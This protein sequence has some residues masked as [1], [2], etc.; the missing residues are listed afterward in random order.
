[1]AARLG[2]VLRGSDTAGRVGGDEF[3]VVCGDL[4]AIDEAFAVAGRLRDAMGQAVQGRRPRRL[5][6]A[7]ASA[8]AV[9]V[10]HGRR[11]EYVL[12]DADL[13]MYRAKTDGARAAS[14]CS[15]SRC[16]HAHAT[17]ANRDQ[18]REAID[19]AT[20]P[21]SNNRSATSRTTSCTAP[22]RCSAGGLRGRGLL[23]PVDFL[24][25]AEDSSSSCD[26][27]LGPAHGLLRRCSGASSSAP[28]SHRRSTSRATAVEGS[29]T[30]SVAQVLAETGRHA[31]RDPT[32]GHRDGA[33]RRRTMISE[34]RRGWRRS[35]YDRWTTSGPATRHST[36]LSRS[37]PFPQDRSQLRGR[38]W[39]AAGGRA[40]IE[41]LVRLGNSLTLDVMLRHRDP[42]AARPARE[43][44][45]RYAQG[46]F[47]GIPA[48]PSC[49]STT[50]RGG[51]TARWWRSR[52]SPSRASGRATADPRTRPP[53]THQERGPRAR[54]PGYRPGCL[55]RESSSRSSSRATAT[56]AAGCARPA[57]RSRARRPP[58]RR[59][60]A[61]PRPPA[62]L[63]SRCRPD[64]PALGTPRRQR[65]R[66]RRPSRR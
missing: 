29:F 54:P 55:A 32:R 44:R 51:S 2:S 66:S 63:L 30:Q 19:R 53:G 58:Q 3:V 40:I 50:S 6:T 26:R 43:P 38:A 9:G 64:A 37:R 27:T 42:R 8:C 21:C 56:A 33:A 18:L 52:R 36:H 62:A 49:S 25:V 12:R 61:P 16:G 1:V 41:A 31:G 23:S 48:P 14:R 35:A 11:A 45:C 5:C 47:L 39:R 59:R 7:R 34:E 57:R 65:R 60:A 46:F 17:A 4:P 13:A 24:A 15:T 10:V 20:S 28:P 22:R